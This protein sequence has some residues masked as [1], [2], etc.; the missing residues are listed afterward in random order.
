MHCNLNIT[1][2]YKIQKMLI[3]IDPCNIS[4]LLKFTSPILIITIQH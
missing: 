1:K 2:M 3:I 4:K